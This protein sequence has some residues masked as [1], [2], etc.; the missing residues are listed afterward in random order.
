MSFCFLSLLFERFVQSPQVSQAANE[1]LQASL[2]GQAAGTEL[3]GEPR[4]KTKTKKTRF[5]DQQT[6]R[7][8]E[9]CFWFHFFLYDFMMC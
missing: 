1:K 2:Q 7:F 4:K 5:L 6:E 9:G 3:A 8:D